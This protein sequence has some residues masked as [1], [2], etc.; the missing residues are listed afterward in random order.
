MCQPPFRGRDHVL[1][2]Q[3]TPRITY[4]H[5]SSSYGRFTCKIIPRGAQQRF[6]GTGAYVALLSRAAAGTTSSSTCCLP[7]HWL[8][9]REALLRQGTLQQ[10]NILLLQD[11]KACEWLHALAAGSMSLTEEEIFLSPARCSCQPHHQG[12]V[13][14]SSSLL[15]TPTLVG[16]A[17][18]TSPHLQLSQ[19]S[20]EQEVRPLACTGSRHFVSAAISWQG[21]GAVFTVPSDWLCAVTAT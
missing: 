19:W 7:C 11:T 4:G 8:P 16:L 1:H 14:Q 21:V 20:I 13:S 10:I 6:S 2:S 12:S 5:S 17:A 3:F 18:R 15:S 9:D